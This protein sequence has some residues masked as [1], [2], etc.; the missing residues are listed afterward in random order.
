MPAP[1][2]VVSLLRDPVLT[3]QALSRSPRPG[4]HDTDGGHAMPTVRVQFA[5][6]RQVERP[7]LGETSV[8]KYRS[9]MTRPETLCRL[10]YAKRGN[11][12]KGG[13][14]L[15]C[16]SETGKVLVIAFSARIIPVRA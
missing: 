10:F 3:Q 14:L 9:S 2:N 4:R 12:C 15:Y 11:R 16:S 6:H 8:V 5:G 7:L 1:W 13:C